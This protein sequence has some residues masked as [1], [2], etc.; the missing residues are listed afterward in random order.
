[1]LRRAVSPAAFREELM[2]AV[3]LL[4][5]VLGTAPP[6]TSADAR[7]VDCEGLLA[8]LHVI[9]AEGRG[10]VARIRADNAAVAAGGGRPAVDALCRDLDQG[11]DRMRD[12]VR[13]E[14]VLAGSCT[15]APYAAA[16]ANVTAADQKFRAIR[17]RRCGR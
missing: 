14:T 16:L 1:M 6:L 13:T 11:S 9:A 5:A 2:R 17:A 3:A 15:G 8:R 7:V 10:V 4:L 12:V